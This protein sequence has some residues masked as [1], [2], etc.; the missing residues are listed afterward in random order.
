MSRAAPV[1]VVG[2]GLA[3]LSAAVTLAK[4]GCWV[5]VV[6][7]SHAP[8]GAVMRQPLPG[9][10]PVYASPHQAAWQQ[11]MEQV[12][13]HRAQIT[14]QTNTRFGGLD[15]EGAVLL[16]GDQAQ[17]MRP[18]A[19]VLAVGAKERVQ[20]RPGWTLPGVVTAGAV[21]LAIK[22]VGRAP[23]QRVV[24]A[25]SGPLL[26]AVGAQLCVAGT[27]PVAIVESG[28][29]F[30]R[31]W[32]ALGLP[33]SY[34]REAA[35]YALTLRAARVPFFSASDVVAIERGAAGLDVQVRTPSGVRRWECD[36]LGLHDGIRP[37]DTGLPETSA[38][39]V[40]RVGDCRHALGARA[41]LEDGRH[42][43]QVLLA[44]MQG[45]V[46]PPPGRALERERRA[47][48]KLD[49]LYR[50]NAHAQLQQLPAET[51]ICRCE[52]RTLADLRALGEQP[53]ERLLRLQ[54]RFAM[55][56]CQGRFCAE[57]VRALAHP[58]PAAAAPHE[59]VPAIGANRWPVHP[60]AVADLL[61][62]EWP[63]GADT[64]R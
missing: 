45:R 40:V 63:D 56:A 17:W 64:P 29:P 49:V 28:R 58:Q 9:V 47:Q 38:I 57:W 2:A 34:W 23:A 18:C 54:G 52:G 55:G 41:A 21:Q 8:G 4:A 5:H 13:A 59:A 36:V 35:A 37:N 48:H 3:G 61:Q 22:T 15:S 42:G 44:R 33:L 19:V 6:E 10:Q 60:I 51:V 43:A 62:A 11:L 20:P 27:P 25:G 16:T 39:E 12:R 24:L 53:T 31:P 1:L 7:Q 46:A 30:A 32:L 26:M 14:L 50:N